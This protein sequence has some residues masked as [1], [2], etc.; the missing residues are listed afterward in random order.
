M[1]YALI[2]KESQKIK[3]VVSWDGREDTWKPPEGCYAVPLPKEQKFGIGDT[4]D[5]DKKEWVMA[6]D[7][8]GKFED[9]KPENVVE[10]VKDVVDEVLP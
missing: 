1:R 4:Y 5:P 6:E 10:E 9:I 7:R 2:D 3:N 8:K